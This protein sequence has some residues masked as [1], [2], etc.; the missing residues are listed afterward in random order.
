MQERLKNYAFVTCL[1][2]FL[3]IT[4]GGALHLSPTAA[5]IDALSGTPLVILAFSR[6]RNARYRDEARKESPASRIVQ[7]RER[8]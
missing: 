4:I 1:F 2:V 8:P 3:F 5:F 6:W 7:L